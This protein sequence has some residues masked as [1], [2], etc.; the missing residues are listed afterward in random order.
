MADVAA[1]D[2]AAVVGGSRR[3]CHGELQAPRLGGVGLDGGTCLPVW[4]TPV[5]CGGGIVVVGGGDA[6]VVAVARFEHMLIVVVVAV[7]VVVVGQMMGPRW[8]LRKP[9][10]RRV[11]CVICT[12]RCRIGTMG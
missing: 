12:L 8:T 1:V 3:V 11:R 5:H 10:R 4:V 7:V 6:V 2:V 9:Q